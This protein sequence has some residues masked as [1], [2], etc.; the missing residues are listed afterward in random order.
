MTRKDG[1]RRLGAQLRLRVSTELSAELQAYAAK[2]DLSISLAARECLR[3]GLNQGGAAPGQAETAALAG[4]VAAEHVRL[5]VETIIPDGH[6]RAQ[7]LGG[8]AVR[9]AQLRLIEVSSQGTEG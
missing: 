7:A 3:A 8:E 5:L 1:N 4:L 2:R 9:A 6:N